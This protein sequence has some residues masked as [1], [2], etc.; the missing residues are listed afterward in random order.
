MAARRDLHEAQFAFRVRKR[1]LAAWKRAAKRADEPLSSWARKMLN[2]CAT[3]T[4][5]EVPPVVG[6][7]QIEL[8]LK[9][10]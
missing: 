5:A 6:G 10:S 2:L 8:P 7:P 3:S 4:P 1:E 9:K